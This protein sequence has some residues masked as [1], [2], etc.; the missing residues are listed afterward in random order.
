VLF[1]SV[2]QV[3]VGYGNVADDWVETSEAIDCAKL[4]APVLDLLPEPP[5]QIAD[6]GAGTGRDAAWLAEQGHLVAAVEPVSRLREAGRALHPSD[7]IDWI[8]ARLPDLRALARERRFD[9]ILLNGVWQHLDDP[10]RSL[11]VRRFADLSAPGG[12]LVMS[13]RHGPAAAGRPVVAIDPDVTI[14]QAQ[15]VGFWL[16]RR[17]E[18]QSLQAANRAAGVTWTWLVFERTD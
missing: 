3:L 2:E 12:R 18:S 15:S 6:I 1:R 9:L 4:Y 14:A 10:Q 7:R 5:S 13:L 17:R 8:D 16:L 11:A